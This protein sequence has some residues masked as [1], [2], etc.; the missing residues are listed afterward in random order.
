VTQ[1]TTRRT[2]PSDTSTAY[3][4]VASD[5]PE[6]MRVYFFVFNPLK[7]EGP[8]APRNDRQAAQM[9]CMNG[10]HNVDAQ[11]SVVDC[12]ATPTRVIAFPSLYTVLEQYAGYCEEHGG[13]A[14]AELMMIRH[15]SSRQVV[16]KKMVFTDVAPGS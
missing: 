14:R 7:L 15:F 4:E 10:G 13:L 11:M 12:F 16:F 8:E 2:P 3:V 6:I 1:V 9:L 5:Q